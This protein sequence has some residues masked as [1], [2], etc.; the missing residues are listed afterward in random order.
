MGKRENK[1][2]R[3]NDKT[4]K[5]GVLQRVLLEGAEGREASPHP[6]QRR[7]QSPLRDT[8]GNPSQLV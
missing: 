7:T 1:K 2:K 6:C 5:N 4:K 3:K 8:Q